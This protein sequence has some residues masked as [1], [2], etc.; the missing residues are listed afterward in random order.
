MAKWNYS[1]GL[2]QV[3]S[4][5]KG[6]YFP[7]SFTSGTKEEVIGT[8][9]ESCCNADLQMTATDRS[10]NK[11]QISTNAF[12][13]WIFCPFCW[14]KYSFVIRNLKKVMSCFWRCKMG[15]WTNCCCCFRSISANHF[16]CG[17]S[18]H[19]KK[20]KE[21][22]RVQFGNLLICEILNLWMNNLYFIELIT[23]YFMLICY[24]IV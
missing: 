24:L 23:Y 22:K 9:S 16:N 18:I 2:L 10:G 3:I 13:K 21:E 7:K 11:R 6:I 17:S 4:K 19:H 12:R 20:N 5:P 1:L 14:Q 8:Y 15:P